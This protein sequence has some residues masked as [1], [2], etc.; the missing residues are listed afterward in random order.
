MREFYDRCYEI[1]KK[2]PKGKISTY[3]D[4]A[5]ALGTK[6]SRAVGTAMKKNQD[7][8]VPCHRVINSDGFVGGYNGLVGNKID[9]LREEGV[10]VIDGYIDLKKF[11]YDFFGKEYK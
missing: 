8:N 6:A 3:M 10:K 1:V 7:K 2:I 9:A 4:V 5:N 11:R